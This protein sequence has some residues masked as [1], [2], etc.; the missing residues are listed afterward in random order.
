MMKCQLEED[1]L[2]SFTSICFVMTRTSGFN[3]YTINQECALQP[4][5]FQVPNSAAN[6]HSFSS[7][8]LFLFSKTEITGTW[9]LPSAKKISREELVLEVS[10]IFFYSRKLGV[11]SG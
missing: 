5:V 11:A 10:I 3:K 2:P 4:G 6:S 7:G 9:M 8:R 1:L